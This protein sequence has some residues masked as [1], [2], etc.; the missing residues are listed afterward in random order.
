VKP[1]K[2]GLDWHG[3]FKSTETVPTPVSGHP[4]P[5]HIRRSH[6]EGSSPTVRMRL[7]RLTRLTNRI[8]KKL[9]HLKMGAR[10]ICE[11]LGD[12]ISKSPFRLHD[13]VQ[14]RSRSPDP[15]TYPGDGGRNHRSHPSMEELVTCQT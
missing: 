5:G 13:V 12:P 8:S 3:S 14:F 11:G 2:A 10:Q 7:G 4:G 9:L 15:Q 6:V 1:D